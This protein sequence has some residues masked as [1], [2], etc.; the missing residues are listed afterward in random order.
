MI[1]KFAETAGPIVYKNMVQDKNLF[2]TK[3]IFED[4]T[5]FRYYP[6]KIYNTNAAFKQFHFHVEQSKKENNILLETL[7]V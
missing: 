6:E 2:K 4:K 5:L 1:T 3:D 7:L